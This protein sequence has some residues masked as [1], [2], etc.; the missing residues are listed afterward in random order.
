[1]R[2]GEWAETAEVSGIECVGLVHSC[3]SGEFSIGSKVA[4]LMGGMGRSIPGSYAEYTRVPVSNVAL[5][6][7]ELSWEDLAV[8]PETYATAWTVLFRNL[9]VKKGQ[10]LLVRGAT[11]SLGLA[12]VNLAVNEGVEVIAT[13]RSEERFGMLL[14]KGVKDVVLEAP[15]LSERMKGRHV[16]AVLNLVGNSVLLGSLA[17][18]RRGGRVCIAGWLGGLAPVPE[19]NPLLQMP[20]GV[21]FSFFGS[22]HFGLPEFPVSDV[23]LQKIAEYIANG[24]YHAK[25]TKVFR[26]EEIE[27]AQKMMEENKAGGKLVVVV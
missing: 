27:E 16:D 7:V 3:P 20:S 12:A 25:P 15:E 6:N 11:S 4:A 24:Q 1:M 9:E 10:T 13:T 21:Q 26:F 14:E 17:I 19:F 5:I 18:P 23:P 2:K 8:I 22:F